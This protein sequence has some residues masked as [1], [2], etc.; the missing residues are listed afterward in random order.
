[1]DIKVDN[2]AVEKL[3]NEQI[4][5][6]V[7]ATLSAKSDYLVGRLVDEVMR[8]KDRNSYSDDRTIWEKMTDEMVRK[9]AQEAAM[10]WLEEQKPKIVALVRA[11]LGAKS[12]DLIN[13]VADAL[14]ANFAAGLRVNVW[15]DKEC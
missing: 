15:F 11:K 14:V 10:S 1:M 7:A 9:A 12:K 13:K 8:K 6:A 3:V 4:R 5:A 2:E